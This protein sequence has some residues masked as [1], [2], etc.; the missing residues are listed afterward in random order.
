MKRI[1]SLMLALVLVL[2]T[3]M[4][5]APS[6]AATTSDSTNATETSEPKTYKT[7][8]D[9][10]KL[11][12]Y[13]E[14]FM[15]YPQWD[16]SQYTV[17]YGTRCP[18]DKLSE[19]SS[20]GITEYEAE[21]LLRNYLTNSENLINN[22]LI[23]KY[24]LNMTQSQFDALIMFSYNMGGNWVTDTSSNIHKVVVS[25]AVDN[26]IADALT[27]WSK[28]GGKVQNYLIRRRLSESY[29]YL[30]GKY[31][32][33]PPENYCHVRYNGNGGTV[34]Q[35]VQGY[36]SNLKAKVAGTATYGNYTF[37]GWYTSATGGVK[38]EELTQEH[39]KMTLYAH[40][41]EIKYEEPELFDE[42][43][44]VKVTTDDVNLRK[45]PGTNHAT[46]GSADT[47]DQFEIWQVEK[48]GSYTW[49]YFKTGWIALEF[50]N[51]SSVIEGGSEPEET[52]PENTEPEEKPT[53]PE[54]TKPEATEPEVEPTQ[55]AEPET[56]KRTGVVKVNT[57]L[58][59]RTGPGTA[60][61]TV[62]VLYN[63]AKVTILKQKTVG[64]MIWGETPDGWISMSYVVL[65]DEFESD[66]DQ[67]TSGKSGTVTCNQLNVRSGAGITYGIAGSYK[68]ND[69]VVITEQKTVNGVTWGKTA[70]GWVSMDYIKLEG[71][72]SGGNTGSAGNTGSTGGN[73]S[74]VTGK[75][76][77][78][79]ELRIR[80]GAGTTYSIVGF[81]K[82]GDS[83][84]ITEK[85]TVNGTVWGKI[86]KGWVSM[87]Y[88]KLDS[89]GNSD[90]LPEDT[91]DDDDAGTMTRTV[92]VTSLCV[93]KGAGIDND[94]ISWLS[95]GAK[96]TVTETKTVNGQQWGKISTGWICLDYTV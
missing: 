17:G 96:V 46:V 13:E 31:Q 88:I 35:S 39:N 79:D 65:D 93:R 8:D 82:P 48:G 80:S 90:T 26:S 67:E 62:G 24:N 64:S 71:A 56:T 33:T 36:N 22:K 53:E 73:T 28:A 10:I 49:G 25:G 2:G 34:S 81:L 59:V 32:H 70:K 20:R 43:I 5:I 29:M 63:G 55:P 52:E 76:S 74:T 21:Q 27:R 42:P 50:T 77:S 23:K 47:G 51:Y 16:Y 85:K 18:S 45:G 94:A 1:F 4:M 92:N 68:K 57:Y 60:Y 89:T 61:N 7:S 54:A 30:E 72:T 86:S 40:W 44:K 19:Y 78:S 84:T 14:G 69:K 87:D 66:V 58:C 15:K 83:V 37:A 75:V 11:L 91:F 12:K 38:V 6:V 95:K 41:S 3:V 9:L